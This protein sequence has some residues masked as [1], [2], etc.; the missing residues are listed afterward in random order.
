MKL[1]KKYKKNDEIIISS[2]E[3]HSNIIPWQII[4]KK[5]S[6]I[7]KIIPITKNGEININ[8]FEKLLTK[9]KLKLYL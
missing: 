2:M 1:W 9:K 8:C 5:K 3:H 7:L 4:C 6:A